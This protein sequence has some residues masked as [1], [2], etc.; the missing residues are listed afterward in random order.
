MTIKTTLYQGEVELLFDSFR[1]TYTVTDAVN[2]IYSETRPSPPF[3]LEFL[4]SHQNY[5]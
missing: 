2:G 3:Q 4:I 1:H 5:F